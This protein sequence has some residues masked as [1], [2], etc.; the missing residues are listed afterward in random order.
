MIEPILHLLKIHRKMILG[1]TPIIVQDMLRKTPKA[2]NAVTV[3][4]GSFIDQGL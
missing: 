4:L 2:F 3:I 1:N